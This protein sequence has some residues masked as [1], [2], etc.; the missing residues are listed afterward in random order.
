MIYKKLSLPTLIAML[1]LILFGLVLLQLGVAHRY[2]GPEWR[3]TKIVAGY[4][5]QEPTWDE[6]HGYE[7]CQ[8][9][10][11]NTNYNENYVEGASD[12]K[13]AENG[14]DHLLN[15]HKPEPLKKICSKYQC[16]KGE[17]VKSAGCGFGTRIIPRAKMMVS[18]VDMS[19]KFG[20]REA[21]KRIYYY[22][23]GKNNKRAQ[24]MRFVVPVLKQYFLDEDSNVKRVSVAVTIPE[25][26]QDDPP[27]PTDDSVRIEQWNEMKVYVR[28]YGGY[29]EDEDFK[30]QFELLETALKNANITPCT[31]MR[32]VAG[33]TYMRYG[34][35]RLEA[36]LVDKHSV[37]KTW[38][39]LL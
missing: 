7:E 26:F 31:T 17:V 36:I 25:D 1:K 37:A 16:P 22:R 15:R 24:K 33:Y 34:R 23:S 38:T 19:K 32:F 2:K 13:K 20:I 3:Q 5:D 4:K 10:L 30:K 27:T 6:A 21:Y 18:D 9:F 11:N 29:R 39:C 8:E 35:Q 12:D 28:A 14:L